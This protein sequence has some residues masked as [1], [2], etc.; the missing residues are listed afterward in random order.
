[1]RVFSIVLSNTLAAIGITIIVP[2]LG[3]ASDIY[4]VPQSLVMWLMTGFMLTYASFMPVFGA[5]SDIIGRK[6]TFVFANFIFAAGLLISGLSKNFVLVVIGRMIQGLGA[7]GILP[8]A[9]ALAVEYMSDKKERALSIV[10]ATYGLGM[11]LGVNLGGVLYDHLGTSSLYLTP[12]FISVAG[13]ILAIL[14]MKETLKETLSLKSSKKID[15][16]GSSFFAASLMGFMLFMKELPETG[17]KAPSAISYFTLMIVS[18]L[19]FIVFEI[20]SKNPAVDLRT[21][22]DPAYLSGNLTALFF[23]VAMFTTVTFMAPFVQLLFSYDVS[24]S[25][26]SIDPFALAMTIAIMIGGLL[27]KK[28]DAKFTLSIGMVILGV[29]TLIFVHFVN[30]E[31]SFFTL[32]LILALGLGIPMT[33]MNHIVIERG[34]ESRQGTSAAI[35]SIM[36]SIGGIIGPTI[37]GMIFAKTDFSSIFALDNIIESY[38]KIYSMAGFAAIAGLATSLFWLCSKHNKETVSRP[39]KWGEEEGY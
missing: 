31:F 18:L 29:S 30:S 5:L 8:V 23:G 34:G 11:I 14:T 35:V 13:A 4:G 24:T 21:F 16:L 36:R 22:K 27:S 1:M 20:R 39:K 12:F 19:L 26:Y 10:N 15:W 7:G 37:A 3:V 2:L 28:T 25:V 33:P 17:F 38:R 32:S 6:K 9:N